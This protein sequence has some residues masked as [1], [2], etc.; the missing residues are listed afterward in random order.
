M[1]G[2]RYKNS[3]VWT[4]HSVVTVRLPVIMM[5]NIGANP[6]ELSTIPSSNIRCPVPI[7]PVSIIANTR[8]CFSE[9]C[10]A[11]RLLG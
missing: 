4:P 2:A 9:R 7:I 3:L 11:L 10:E 6:G 8:P 5:G 1:L